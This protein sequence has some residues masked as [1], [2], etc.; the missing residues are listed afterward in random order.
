MKKIN[1]LYLLIFL[2]FQSNAFADIANLKNIKTHLNKRLPI[3][4][5]VNN[6][7]LDTS[8][9]KNGVVFNDFSAPDMFDSSSRD[10]IQTIAIQTDNKV[11]TGGTTTAIKNVTNYALA[12]FNTDGKLDQTFGTSGV[13]TTDIGSLIGVTGNDKYSFLTALAIQ[14]DGKIIGAGSFQNIVSFGCLIRYNIDGTID[15]SFGNNGLVLTDIGAQIGITNSNYELNGIV[16]Q[17]DGKII[18]CGL[19]NANALVPFSTDF[20][21][22]IVRYNTDGS[23]DTTFGTNG[24]TIAPKFSL[25]G[26]NSIIQLQS[27]GKIVICGINK[28]TG[29]IFAVTRYNSNGTIDNTF[30]TNGIVTTNF[31]PNC[32]ANS[33]V[34]YLDKIIVSG[35][36][37]MPNNLVNYVMAK[38]NADGSL[39]TSFGNN[40]TINQSKSVYIE[41]IAIQSDGKIVTAGNRNISTTSDTF[42]LTRLNINGSFDQTFGTNGIVTTPLGIDFFQSI[43]I[44][45]SI[46]VQANGKILVGGI[47]DAIDFNNDFILVK[48]N[49]N[50]SLDKTFGKTVSVFEIPGKNGVSDIDFKRVLKIP[51]GASNSIN[52]IATQS[53]GQIIVAGFSDAEDPN[54]DFASYAY[55]TDGSLPQNRSLQTIDFSGYNNSDS[56]N[57]GSYD[58]ANCIAMQKNDK[59]IIAG[60]SD[61]IEP[62][63][64]FALVRLNQDGI[65]DTTFGTSA[66]A[67]LVVTNFGQVQGKAITTS[68][69]AYSI[70]LQADDKIVAGG[71]SSS[72][73]INTTGSF[74]L[75][76]YNSDGSLDTS[77]GYSNNGLVSINIGKALGLKESLDSIFS[78]ALQT[79][80]KIVAGGFTTAKNRLGDFALMRFNTNG[81]VDTTFGNNGFVITNFD[82]TKPNIS[83]INKIAIQQDGKIVAGGYTTVNIANF[84]PSKPRFNFGLTRYNTNG[85]LDTTFGNNGFVVTEL[86]PNGNNSKSSDYLLSLVIKSDG[87]IVA[88]GSSNAMDPNFDFALAT[89]QT[90]GSL[91]KSV[92]RNG[93]I[94]TDFATT[95]RALGSTDA[96][97]TGDMTIQKDGKILAAGNTN[98]TNANFDFAGA[99]YIINSSTLIVNVI[100]P[101]NGSTIDTK[102]PTILGTVSP[103]LNNATIKVNVLIDGKF[104]GTANVVNGNWSIQIT[105][106]L[107]VGKHTLVATATSSNGLTGTTTITFT[108][109]NCTIT[110]NVYI[111]ALRTK[112]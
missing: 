90:N 65:Q 29:F 105:Q 10:I 48:Y 89:Y 88:G 83:Q 41:T 54:Y 96:I 75:A 92:G 111:N 27:D 93:V 107:T 68:D 110:N 56:T 71:I 82:K 17:P 103:L 34:L 45:N 9:G 52:G 102:T 79:D 50:G 28:P 33:L 101:Q 3:K 20:T 31:G 39:D 63:F 106:P 112:Y 67:N 98:F 13:V 40:G 23:I 81:T 5:A 84:N 15:T 62:T 60:L 12:R 109:A 11:V 43:T 69:V 91:N 38:Y 58:I 99:R 57:F 108:V 25:S 44:P 80:G 85:S 22:G 104:I 87:T 94:F 74:A 61:V 42:C 78:I 4:R 49:S 18:A 14:S 1:S 55:S 32:F 24:V 64:S 53:N 2:I 35:K 21:L 8:F 26:S 47:S 70:L 46:K 51:N 77:Y 97:T 37:P 59:Y 30:G 72:T 73:D 86:A 36:L 6:S 76:R 66:H 7:G 19:T 100:T 16:L 95:A